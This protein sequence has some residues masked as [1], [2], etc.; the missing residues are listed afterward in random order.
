MVPPLPLLYQLK[1]QKFRT[2]FSFLG[3]PLQ[4]AQRGQRFP[5]HILNILWPRKKAQR[6]SGVPLRFASFRQELS[7]T[8]L[9]P[10]PHSASM[11]GTP[12]LRNKGISRSRTT[13]H[14]HHNA[15]LFGDIFVGFFR[16]TTNMFLHFLEIF[17]IFTISHKKSIMAYFLLIK[18]FTTPRNSESD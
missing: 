3:I 7:A 13:G 9:Q 12:S 15:A 2:V 1:A 14:K 5:P 4:T 6:G 10:L 18:I 17:H 8:L 11:A 16:R